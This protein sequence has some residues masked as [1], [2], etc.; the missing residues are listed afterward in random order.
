MIDDKDH[1]IE[2]TE[3]HVGEFSDEAINWRTEE[4]DAETD[5][6][7]EELDETPA[8]VVEVLGFDPKEFS[9][10]TSE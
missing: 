8:D 1:E 7:D 2:S 4:N 5:P 10:E 9:E 6:D 3:F